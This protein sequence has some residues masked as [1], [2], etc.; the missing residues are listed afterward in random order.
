MADS[1]R[2]TCV[3]RDAVALV[4]I[5]RPDK[6]N[7]LD[8]E[9]IAGLGA[10]YARCDSD[11]DVRVVIVTGAG[12]AFCSG[13]DL[14]PGR[15][16][17]GAVADPDTF[18]SSPVRPR[19]WEVRKPVIAAVNG[20]AIGLGLSIALQADLRIVARDAPLAVLQARRGVL[21]DAQSHWVLPRLV[22][23]ARAAQ[24]L[25]A[26]RTITGMQ[27]AEW[28]MANE[29]VEAA[30]V[31]SVAMQWAAD[32]VANVS[33]LSAAL[34]KRTMWRGLAATPDEVDAMERD[35]H[36]MLMG[37]PDSIEGGR[38]FGERRQPVWVS[39]VPADWP[40]PD[41]DAITD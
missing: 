23:T 39:R 29:A 27:A 16:P 4:T 3:V 24:M 36:L 6:R 32:I 15:S 18:Q 31:L 19:A 22:G 17:F 9:M 38:A 10:A 40:Y 1:D 20:A 12:S 37:R 35:A 21:P 30:D 25:I 2:L 8:G 14:S 34:S 26:G 7:A 11:D 33:P 28:G 13:A 41:T 5:N